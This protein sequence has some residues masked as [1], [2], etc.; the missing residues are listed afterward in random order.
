MSSVKPKSE[1]TR[2]GRSKASPSEATEAASAANLI[3]LRALQSMLDSLKEDICGRIDSLTSD[4]RTEISSVRTELK[5]ATEPL[6]QKINEH[7][8]TLKELELATSDHGDRLSSLDSTVNALKTQVKTLTDKCEDLEGRSRRNNLRLVGIPEGSEGQRPTEFIGGLLKDLL[9]LDEAP[10]LDRAHR[11]L[12]AKPRTGEPPRPVL[13]RVHFFH[14]RNEILRRANETSR[15]SPLLFQGKKL[16][17]FPDYTA[18]V[19]KRRAAF[20]G[21]KR[22]LWACPGVKFGLMYPALLKITLPGGTTH[23]FED[24]TEASAFV[25]SK[26]RKVVPT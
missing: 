23:T 8:Q 4:L 16:S 6:L 17:I 15:G 18:A 21:V 10:L 20:G 5:K 13:I 7:G 26:L 11:T 14:I 3:D 2:G 24:P 22:E 1:L 9:K 12:R 25:S 19:A